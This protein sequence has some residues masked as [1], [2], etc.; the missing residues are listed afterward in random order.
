[1][2]DLRE[3]DL[4][5]TK[6]WV[7]ERARL[8]AKQGEYGILAMEVLM[9]FS[10]AL[11]LE[12]ARRDE[13]RQRR[14]EQWTEFLIQSRQVLAQQVLREQVEALEAELALLE[15]GTDEKIE[16]ERELFRVRHELALQTLNDQQA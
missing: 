14:E 11:M 13:E 8:L 2:G 10:E 3:L 5:S 4:E 6:A 16:L 12:E 7:E 1:M 15:D 9:D